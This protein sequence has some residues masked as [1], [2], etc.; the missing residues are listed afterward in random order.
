MP[1]NKRITRLIVP[2]VIVGLIS[3]QQSVQAQNWPIFR[4]D[5]QLQGVAAVPFDSSPKLLWSLKPG[6][7][8]KAAPV[9]SDGIMVVGSDNGFLYALN[10]AGKKLWEFNTEN[11]V[12][13]PALILNGTVYI[14]NLYGDLFA[15]DLK[16]GELKW[17]YLTDNQISGSVNFFQT[18]EK[19]YLLVGSYDYFLHCIDADTGE[20]I[21][22]YESDNFINGAAGIFD[23]KAVFGGCDGFLH[24]IDIRTGKPINKVEV[25]TYVAS[26][27]AIIQQEAFLGDY[28]GR[29]SCVDLIGGE[30]AWTYSHPELTLPFIGSPSVKNDRVVI[31]NRDKNVY[32]FHRI[33]G[34]LLWKTNSG[35]RVD[36]SP[37][38]SG[39]QVLIAN[40]RG[41]LQILDLET[42][43]I[44][45]NYEIGSG[46]IGNP[47][48]A[49]GKIWV[50]ASDGFIYFFGK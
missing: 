22:K 19:C 34:R 31:G 17:K 38:I 39:N 4:G 2:M 37:V 6:D 36:A 14:G 26:S 47:A 12:E 50:A 32:C 41:D 25:A 23:G 16:T 24:I 18:P 42:G 29:F 8:I 15:L 44:K 35:S 20:N 45:W 5:Q 40:M 9:V 21:W 13:A 10:E 7:G 49:N 28:D 46:I 48:V 1:M 27:V 30:I 33:D 11:A 43:E 3:C